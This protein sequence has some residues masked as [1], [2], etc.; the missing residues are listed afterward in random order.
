[1]RLQ[2][3]N[4]RKR[5]ETMF[6]SFHY[7][8]SDISAV[9]TATSTPTHPHT[10]AHSTRTRTLPWRRAAR[11]STADRGTLRRQRLARDAPRRVRRQLGPRMSR[12]R[13]MILSLSLSLSLSR[14]FAV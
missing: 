12:Y 9:P 11:G 13:D 3:Y 1:M 10:H 8:S 6:K 14:G 5:A 2:Y 7:K 4:L